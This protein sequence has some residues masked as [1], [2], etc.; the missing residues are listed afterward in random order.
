MSV[1]LSDIL[2]RKQLCSGSSKPLD[3]VAFLS[4]VAFFACSMFYAMIGLNPN[5]NPNRN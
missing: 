5:P 1:F 4:N 2:L 3:D